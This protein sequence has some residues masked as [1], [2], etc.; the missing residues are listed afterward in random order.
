MSVNEQMLETAR[1]Y[2]DPC[3]RQIAVFLKNHVGSLS[4]VLAHLEREKVLC[5]AIA[6]NNNVDFA[7]LRLI[8]DK[9]ETA[10]RVLAEDFQIAE[11]KLIA[12]ELPDPNL[13]MLKISRALLRAEISIHYT[14]PMFSQPND[15]PVALVHLD[16]LTTGCEVLRKCGYNLIDEIDLAG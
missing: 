7:I 14:Y 4:E 2:D 16:D 13:G 15:K 1:A 3:V 8:V 6:I 9:Y 10:C 5:H 12:V 11:S